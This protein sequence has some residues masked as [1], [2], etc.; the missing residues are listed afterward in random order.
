ML[1]PAVLKPLWKSQTSKWQGL[2]EKHLNEIISI[3]EEVTLKIFHRVSQQCA[4]PARAASKLEG[5]IL[6]FSRK[7]KQQALSALHVLCH[8]NANMALQTTN[9]DFQKRVRESQQCRFKQAIQRYSLGMPALDFI[10]QKDTNAP[11]AGL[12]AAAKEWAIVDIGSMGMLFNEMHPNGE[13]AQNTEDEIH[14]ILRAYYDVRS[15]KPPHVRIHTNIQ[16][17]DLYS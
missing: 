2:S 16:P 9:P 12:T 17:I 11:S 13:R 14:D 6:E 10:K 1:N 4:L 15:F 7:S 3:T 5:E 8:K